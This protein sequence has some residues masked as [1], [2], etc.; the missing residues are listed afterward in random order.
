[1]KPSQTLASAQTPGGETLECIEHDQDIYLYLNRQPICSTRA[2]EPEV[3]LARAGC[4]RVSTYRTPKILL[5]GLGLGHCLH[6]VLT[7]APP[8]ANIHLVEPMKPLIDWHREL[9]GEPA[10][11]ALQ[12]SRLAIHTASA[13]AIMKKVNVKFDSIMLSTDPS[14]TTAS[15]NTLRICADNL[16]PKGLIC[17]KSSRENTSKIRGVLESCRLHTMITPVG[18]R[19]G[20]RTRAHAIICAAQRTEFL[21]AIG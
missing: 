12:D 5:A 19:P 15:R 7:L 4:S 3:A 11:D 21:P 18:A 2:F 16:N 13:A 6:E 10:R 17:I 8:K 14:M 20:A 9:L 1:M